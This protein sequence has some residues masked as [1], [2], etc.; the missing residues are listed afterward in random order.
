M[1]GWGAAF[2]EVFPN[3]CQNFDYL[4]NLLKICRLLKRLHYF[5]NNDFAVF[6][7]SLLLEARFTPLEFETIKRFAS[8]FGYIFIKLC[9]S[10]PQIHSLWEIYDALIFLGIPKFKLE[11]PS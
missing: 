11:L 10:L 7:S 8:L 5:L 9:P 6:T 4:T 2:P 1:H 3:F